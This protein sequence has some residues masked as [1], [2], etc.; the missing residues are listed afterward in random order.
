[1]LKRFFKQKNSGAGRGQIHVSD[2]LNTLVINYV[3]T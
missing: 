2:W 3:A 1:M